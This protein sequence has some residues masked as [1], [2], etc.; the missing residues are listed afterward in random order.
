MSDDSSHIIFE[1]VRVGADGIA[2]MDGRLPIVFVPRSN[3]VAVEVRHGSGA[4]RPLITLA[5][6]ALLIAL[7]FMPLLMI[8]NASRRAE[9]FPTKVIA[10]VAFVVPG[11]WLLDLAVR[12]RW[13]LHVETR[14]G[15]KKILFSKAVNQVS[16]ESFVSSARARFG[17]F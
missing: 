9:P 11:L 17:Y 1:S 12:R 6:G 10:A 15:V 2:E 5:V 14:R 13:F 8:A 7:S 3:I 4:Q 16:V